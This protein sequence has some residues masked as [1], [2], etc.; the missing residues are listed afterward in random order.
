[1]TP[2][3]LILGGT[4]EATALAKAVSEAGLKATLSLAGRV[5]R[6]NRQPLPTRVGGFGGVAG[7]GSFMAEAGTTHL[8]DATHPFANSMSQNAFGASAL[9]SIP[10]VSLERMPW[11]M[12]AADNWRIVS[13]MTAAVDALQGPARRVFLGIGRQQAGLF[14]ARP[15]HHYVIRLIDLPDAPLDVP[16]HRILQ[17]RGPF[18][19]ENDLRLLR[20]AEIDVVVSKNSGGTAAYSKIAA[21]RALG[22]PVIMVDRPALPPR[23]VLRSVPEVMAWIDATPSHGAAQRGV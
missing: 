8:I 13:D 14:A 10:H 7:L 2:N 5:A 1:M 9:H 20:E 19:F 4:T 17:D 12:E 21:A 16:D 6:P 3:L 22:L 23:L 11:A 15:Q 18:T